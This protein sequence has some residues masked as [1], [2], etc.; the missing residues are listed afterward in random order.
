MLIKKIK[1][2]LGIL[3]RKTFTGPV[4][5]SV[6]LTRQCATGCLMCWYWS[7]LL[8]ERP[9][10]EWACRQIEY[11]VLL[12]L[13]GDFKK[14]NVKRLIFGGQGD[15]FLHPRMMDIVEATKKAGIGTAIITAGNYFNAGKIKK[16]VELKTDHLDVSVQAATPEAYKKVHPALKEGTF[17][18]IRESLLLLS[19]LKKKAGQAQPTVSI[20]D[21]VC[22]AN[23][24][25][26]V[27]MVEFAH[28]VGAQSVGY[29]RVDVIPET[30]SMLLNETQV[31]ELRE[32]LEKAEERAAGLGIETSAGSYGKYII[33]GLTSGDYTSE[34]YSRIPC[35]VGWLSSRILSDGSVIPCCG[36]YAPPLG[37]INQDTFAN[38]WNSEKYRE[39]RQK[40]INILKNPKLVENCKCSSCV[41]F[42]FNFGVYRRL[43]PFK[44]MPV[45]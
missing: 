23:Y 14:L 24:L 38:I 18:R 17:E 39:F 15:P 10:D 40:S 20:I 33:P 45:P 28:E 16:L 21:A 36:C 8:K 12:K 32:L 26:T 4:E 41:D 31:K 35:Y 2:A 11:D 29:K 34:Y 7:P 19:E 25:D 42:E 37:N 9:S 43:H 30:R 6:D 27:E 44:A 3:A 5:V 1:T 22:S 13:L